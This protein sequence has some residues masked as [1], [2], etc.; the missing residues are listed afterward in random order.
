MCL[1]RSS[2]GS[3]LHY[4]V[5]PPLRQKDLRHP[6][7]IIKDERWVWDMNPPIGPDLAAYCLSVWEEHRGR[8]SQEGPKV[9]GTHYKKQ[10]LAVLQL[11]VFKRIS[12][13][14]SSIV[15]QTVSLF[16]MRRTPARCALLELLI[17]N[18][19]YIPL[20][21]YP[22]PPR[23]PDRVIKAQNTIL[24]QQNQENEIDSLLKT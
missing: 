16:P 13:S 8:T 12:R 7:P 15:T 11:P 20:P 23:K 24:L 14:T 4:R 5:K 17:R 9:K 22:P 10:G 19:V 1:T 2:V 21:I 6:Y 3:T 18:C